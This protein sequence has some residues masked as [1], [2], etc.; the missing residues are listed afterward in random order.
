MREN[1]ILV[2]S[3]KTRVLYRKW[4]CWQFSKQ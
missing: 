1:Q 2:W 4:A 3:C